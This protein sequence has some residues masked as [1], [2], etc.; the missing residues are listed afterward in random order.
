MAAL[1]PYVCRLQ[2][3][4]ERRI[5]VPKFAPLLATLDFGVLGKVQ[6]EVVDISMNGIGMI[7]CPAD[8]VLEPG[9]CLNG[10]EIRLPGTGAV[11]ADLRV[12]HIKDLT[13]SGADQPV[14][15]IGCEFIAPQAEL[16]ALIEHYIVRLPADAAA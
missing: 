8:V 11:A 3:R 15:R 7:A 5:K 2:R 1:P 4:R 9:E 10:C 14:R 16:T 12:A 6:V 13:P